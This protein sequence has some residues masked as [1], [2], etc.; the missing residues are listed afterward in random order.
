MS[1][2][3]RLPRFP[4]ALILLLRACAQLEVL[5]KRLR[6]EL[7]HARS[8]LARRVGRGEDGKQ[9]GWCDARGRGF[10]RDEDA[11]SE[12]GVRQHVEVGV[13]RGVRACG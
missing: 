1:L 9:R 7:E 12:G 3:L 10:G 8:R 6:G 2:R 5:P 11:R 4:Q 13:G